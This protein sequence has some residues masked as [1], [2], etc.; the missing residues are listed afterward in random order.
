MMSGHPRSAMCSVSG[1]AL[2]DSTSAFL[3]PRRP[4][5]EQRVRDDG[6]EASRAR[7][8]TS[9]SPTRETCRRSRFIADG[10]IPLDECNAFRLEQFHRRTRRDGRTRPCLSRLRQS[11]ISGP[12]GVHA[13]HPL[14]DDYHF[15]R[16]YGRAPRDAVVL[17]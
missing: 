12:V 1:D 10:P 16:G 17:G 3:A 8:S 6:P 9:S 14:M 13:R 15:I 5:R 4:L 2:S 7:R 11:V